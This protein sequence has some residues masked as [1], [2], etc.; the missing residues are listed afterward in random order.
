VAGARAN[1]SSCTA[2]RRRILARAL[3]SRIPG[4]VCG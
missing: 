1:R 3:A 2:W 4:S